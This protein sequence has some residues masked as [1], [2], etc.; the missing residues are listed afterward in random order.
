MPFVAKLRNPLDVGSVA[1]EFVSKRDNFVLAF[2]QLSAG[3]CHCRG[4]V[5]VEKDLHA[6]SRDFSKFTAS[7]TTPTGTSKSWL[8]R[9][10]DSSAFTASAS[11]IVGIPC[12]LAIGWPNALCG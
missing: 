9:F 6:A 11:A 10:T 5:V 3:A 7:L 8:T 4:H 1:L 2:E 12:S